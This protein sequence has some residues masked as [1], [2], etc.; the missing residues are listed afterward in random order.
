MIIVA[1]F[2]ACSN[3]VGDIQILLEA[4]R[5]LKLRLS[6]RIQTLAMVA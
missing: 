3:N 6:T 2:D 5:R 1:V 4:L